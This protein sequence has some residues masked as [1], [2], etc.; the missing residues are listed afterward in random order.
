MTETELHKAAMS[1]GEQT[2]RKIYE[3]N[4][5]FLHVIDDYGRSPLFRAVFSGKE[6]L[7]RFFFGVWRSF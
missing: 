1:G 2:C 3:E 7:V 6:T 5:Q 4:P